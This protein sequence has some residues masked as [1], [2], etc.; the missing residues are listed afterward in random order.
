MVLLRTLRVAYDQ[1]HGRP[2]PGTLAEED[3]RNQQFS[4][5]LEALRRDA[6]KS[7]EHLRAECDAWLR[8]L[9]LAGIAPEA[10]EQ[11]HRLGPVLRFVLREGSLLCLGAPLALVASIVTWPARRFG[12]VL[13]LRSTGG[14]ESL[15]SIS[16]ILGISFLLVSLSVVLAVV[17]L[18]FLGPWWALLAL[19]G[20]TALYAFHVF[21]TDLRVS[22]GERTR[23]FLLLAGGRLRENLRAQRRLLC[24]HLDAALR[25]AEVPEAALRPE[26]GG[27]P[28]D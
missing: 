10:L 9:Q 22:I 12:E 3:E 28:R 19:V 14:N 17:S 5:G 24:E 8:A 25:H 15:W 4:R 16:R 6:P 1:E 27:A 23:A 26:D 21:W 2:P 18:V 7:V 13:A 11:Q 20:P